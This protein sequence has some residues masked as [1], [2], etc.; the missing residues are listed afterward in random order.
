[1]LCP[2][3]LV[4]ILEVIYFVLY[5]FFRISILSYFFFPNLSN[6]EK[7]NCLKLNE[8]EKMD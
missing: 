3:L 8:V 6:V 7:N 1:M 2:K 4:K 5:L